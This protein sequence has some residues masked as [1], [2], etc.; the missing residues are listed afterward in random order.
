MFEQTNKLL[1]EAKTPED[2]IG[3]Q[4]LLTK[5]SDEDRIQY[6]THSEQGPLGTM[7]KA[8]NYFMLPHVLKEISARCC[9]AAQRTKVLSLF[10][11]VP[12]D[13]VESNFEGFIKYL[14]E[15]SKLSWIPINA[16]V[17]FLYEKV[18]TLKAPCDRTF[19]AE[20]TEIV[21]QCFERYQELSAEKRD[22]FEG[23]VVGFYHQGYLYHP[24]L[25]VDHVKLQICISYTI[26]RALNNQQANPEFLWNYIREFYD[27]EKTL[28]EIFATYAS[29]YSEEQVNNAKMLL[30]LCI[31]AGSVGYKP[32]LDKRDSEE[33]LNKIR[34]LVYPELWVKLKLKI[35]QRIAFTNEISYDSTK[36]RVLLNNHPEIDSI[37]IE[38]LATCKDPWTPYQSFE[39]YL[40]GR[41]RIERST[42]ELGH[43]KRLVELSKPPKLKEADFIEQI[44]SV[45]HLLLPDGLISL[46][47]KHDLRI[48]PNV[49]ITFLHYSGEEKE[50]KYPTRIEAKEVQKTYDAEKD[51]K[52]LWMD[53]NLKQLCP[54]PK[55]K[56]VV[57]E[58]ATLE[59]KERVGKAAF[60]V[61]KQ[62]FSEAKD[63]AEIDK[64][65]KLLAWAKERDNL[66]ESQE[67]LRTHLS[68]LNKELSHLQNP[69]PAAVLLPPTASLCV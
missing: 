1:L 25:P 4:N 10:L 36:I 56:S 17:A 39:E 63:H 13:Q 26:I 15:C 14:L 12:R 27:S 46:C 21:K 37:D 35:T 5:M 42:K 24:S 41:F 61:F 65:V 49:L 28:W 69:Q 59:W 38:A 68:A 64:C 29:F 53:K 48:T 50:T 40:S 57:F 52:L 33:R 22:K 32:R 30:Q 66:G 6:L 16:I 51:P 8:E 9:T 55:E 3:F 19:R 58:V 54:R 62:I 31:D 18:E 60:A 47:N 20:Q 43:L 34:D 11:A 2:I 67:V 7:I 45:K 23:W 44:K